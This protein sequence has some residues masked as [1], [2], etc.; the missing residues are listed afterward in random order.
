[1]GKDVLSV[2]TLCSVLVWFQKT[3]QSMSVLLFNKLSWV[4]QPVTLLMFQGTP[5]VLE[6]VFSY[7][8]KSR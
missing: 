8:Q 3:E 4:Q 7:S 1:M 6:N 2:E 5:D